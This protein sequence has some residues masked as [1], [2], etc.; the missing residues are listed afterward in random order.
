[1]GRPPPP[2]G[3]DAADVRPDGI[4]RCD[5]GADG[6]GDDDGHGDGTAHLDTDD[7]RSDD[8]MDR[9]SRDDATAAAAVVVP[10]ARS[11]GDRRIVG[12]PVDGVVVPVG[13]AVFRDAVGAA[14]EHLDVVVD[15]DGRPDIAGADGGAD[16][17]ADIGGADIGGSDIGGS[18]IGRRGDRVADV[19][20]CRYGR[21][22]EGADHEEEAHE[23]AR[24]EAVH[25]EADIGGRGDRAAD[26]RGCRYGRTD[27]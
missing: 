7:V 17:G 24:E 2:G 10:V 9:P 11:D 18:D 1:M 15:D 5:G 6:G 13:R 3:C 23:E 14:D 21:T 20:G 16:G 22:D 19:R 8:G 25:E 12:L 4:R 26:V 27:E